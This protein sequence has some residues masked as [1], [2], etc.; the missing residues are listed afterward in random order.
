MFDQRLAADRI[1]SKLARQLGCHL[2]A[3]QLHVAV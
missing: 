2:S 3:E 1:D